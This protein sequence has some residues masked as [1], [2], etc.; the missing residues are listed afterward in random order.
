[1]AVTYGAGNFGRNDYGKG[2]YS[3]DA[4]TVSK[5]NQ[6]I[7]NMFQTDFLLGKVN[8]TGEVSNCKYH[9]SGHIYFTLKDSGSSLACVMFAGDRRG[10]NFTLRDGMK[11]TASGSI[12]VYERDG[13]YQL[14]AK[15]IRKDGAG[16]LY[17]RYLALKNELE[18]MGMFDASFKRPIP[19]YALDIG[20]VTAET[21]AVIHDIQNVAYRRNPYVQLYLYPVKV[22]GEG[23][24]AS[25]CDGIRT[26]DAMKLDVIIVGRGGGSIEDLWAFNEECV[27]RTI[28]DCETPVIS[29]VGHETD[30][31]IADFVSDMR[32][33]TPSAAAELAVFDYAQWRERIRQFDDCLY[34]C[35]YDKIRALRNV[36][37]SVDLRLNSCAPQRRLSDNR[38]YLD[39]LRQR[40]DTCIDR[41]I[42]DDKNRLKL[43]AAKLSALSPLAKL[44][45]GFGYLENEA[46][47]ALKT[48]DDIECGEL[49]KI[50]MS[51]G[52]LTATVTGK[53]KRDYG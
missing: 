1:M 3:E 50:R 30:F 29:A 44:G 47:K 36:L 18:E 34:S 45:G 42:Y 4:Y 2:T 11:V 40:L 15:S 8:V 24:A 19:K 26:L 20:V 28:F 10:L 25:I 21:G 48:V 7:K 35:M 32:A 43:S 23:A 13:K 27:A 49:I 52:S 46:G 51:D 37:N 14:Y 12:S 22:Q 53:E 39:T 38:Q 16:A 6:Y 9:S 17:E 5:I 41:K 31:T 33:P